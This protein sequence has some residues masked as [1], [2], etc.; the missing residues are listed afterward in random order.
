MRFDFLTHHI[1]INNDDRGLSCRG[2]RGGLVDMNEWIIGI[3]AVVGEVVVTTITGLIVQHLWKKRVKEKEELEALREKERV[4]A[5]Q[6]RCE[7]VKQSIHDEL[8]PLREDVDL[9]KH[10]MQKDIRRSLRQDAQFYRNRGYATHQEKTEFDEL[11]W[12]YHNLGKNGVVDH[13]HDEVM[14]LPEEPKGE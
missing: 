3:I 4:A 13:D 11:Y 14:S 6:N 10:S 1:D 9:M 8:K 12:A 7:L 2:S 5:E